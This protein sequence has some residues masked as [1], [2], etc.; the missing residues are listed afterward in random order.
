MNMKHSNE[1]DEVMQQ[2]DA[3]GYIDPGAGSSM[4]QIILA[5]FFRMSARA[6]S[7]FK[8]LFTTR[9]SEE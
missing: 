3:L 7:V 2:L 6:S 4:W 1:E 8:K 5:G 9:N